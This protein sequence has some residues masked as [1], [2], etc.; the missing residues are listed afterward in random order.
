MLQHLRPSR[1]ASNTDSWLNVTRK[2]EALC[3][4]YPHFPGGQIK[5]AASREEGGATSFACDKRALT[6]EILNLLSSGFTNC[7]TFLRQ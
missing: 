4:Q 3:E 2:L 6:D 7:P 5:K 1:L